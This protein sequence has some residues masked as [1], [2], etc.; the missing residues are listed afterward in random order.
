MNAEL[1]SYL[2][3]SYL[4]VCSGGGVIA[5][6]CGV[7]GVSGEVESDMRK[8]RVVVLGMVVMQSQVLVCMRKGQGWG[9]V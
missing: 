2:K 3:C 7:G 1:F 9:Q 8:G 4:P 6:A 5:G